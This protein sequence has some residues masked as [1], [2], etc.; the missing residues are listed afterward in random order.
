MHC[1]FDFHDISHRRSVSV[2]NFTGNFSEFKVILQGQNL[3]TD[4][5]PLVTA[6]LWFKVVSPKL[7]IWLK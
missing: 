2:L 7:A 1:D 4:H 6:R 3:R 5:L